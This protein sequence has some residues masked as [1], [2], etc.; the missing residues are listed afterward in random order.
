MARAKVARHQAPVKAAPPRFRYWPWVALAAVMIFAAAVRIRL[1]NIPLERDEG[2]FAYMGQL[3]LQGIPPYKLAFNMKLPG[4]YAAYAL[5]MAVF[6]QTAAGIHLGILVVNLAAILMVFLLG[7]RLFDGYTGVVAAA[8]YAVMTVVP[9]FLGFA[10]HATHFVILLALCG[11]LVMLRAIASRKLV[12]YLLSG[13]LIGLSFVV[14]QQG[15]FLGIFVGL[16]ILWSGLRARPI[17]PGRL[18]LRL[19]L[20]TFGSALPFGLTCLWLKLVGVFDQFWFWTF[21]YAR[22]YASEQSLSQGYHSFKA[23]V[24]MSISV[25]KWIWA[26]GGIGLLILLRDK[27]LRGRAVFLAGFLLFSFLAVC[28]GM[29]FREHYWILMLP[30]VSLL[31]GLGVS[32]GGRLLK[33]LIGSPWSWMVPASIL[34]IVLYIP[35]SDSAEFLFHASPTQAARMRYGDNPFPEAVEIAKYIKSHTSPS[36]RIAVI[37]SE[38]EIYFYSGRKSATGHIYMY[39]LTEKQAFA[40]K[41]QAEMFEQVEAARPKYVVFVGVGASFMFGAGDA[42]PV[43]YWFRNYARQNLKIVGV[44]DILPRKFTDYIWGDKAAKYQPRSPEY[45]LVLEQR[46]LTGG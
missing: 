10:G 14:K 21:Q 19:A 12:Y 9:S 27:S 25:S 8:A 35:L 28:P 11:I 24:S 33:P 34:L 44:A 18:V 38:P 16:F 13:L 36:D 43:I 20:F 46:D 1:L 26:L 39:G 40:R 41:M 7:K 5:V 3:M 23:M 4:I 42:G 31:A 30:A 22:L 32:S 29:Y 37:G 17:E 45:I 6:G 15:A 2:E